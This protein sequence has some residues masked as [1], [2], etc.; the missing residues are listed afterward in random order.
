MQPTS[1]ALEGLFR[2][3][4]VTPSHSGGL[5]LLPACKP[6]QQ[7]LPMQASLPLPPPREETAQGCVQL[8]HTSVLRW[9][10]CLH[11]VRWLQS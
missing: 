3:A 2:S 6:A 9:P 10:M 4:A 7:A 8:C 11:P 1:H 5:L